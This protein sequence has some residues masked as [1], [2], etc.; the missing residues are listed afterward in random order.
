MS[1]HQQ[2]TIVRDTAESNNE[3]DALK[4]ALEGQQPDVQPENPQPVEDRPE[5]LPEKFKDPVELAKAYSELEK[6]V[7][8]PETKADFAGLEKYS[9][10][11]YAN[12]DISEE[13]VKE[14]VDTYG[15]PETMVRSY[16]EGQR[17]VLDAETNA[18]MQLAGGEQAYQSM[19]DW[20]AGA[21][22]EEEIDAFN[23]IIDG[24]NPHAVRMAVEGLKSRYQKENGSQGRLIQGEVAGPSGGAYR[25]VAEIVAA[26]KDPRYAKDPAYRK[27]VEQRVALSNALGVSS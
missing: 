2:V 11:F 21:L 16:I 5:W 24:R 22:P 14:I 4:A 13:S 20:A 7:G 15:L 10:E 27:D 25:S 1:N 12:G 17:S 6:R 19:V 18:V 8:S 3:T 9:Q 26:M 23:A